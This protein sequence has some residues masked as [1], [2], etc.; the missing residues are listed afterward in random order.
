M[1]ASGGVEEDQ[2][3]A[4]LFCVLDGGL[5]DIDRVRGAHLEDGDIEL[6]AHGLQLLDSGGTV[7]ITGGEQRALAL[8]AH[9][10]GELCT[11]G[12][13]ARALQADQHH[14]ARRLGADVELAV[15]A[16]HEGAQLVVDDLDDHL[17][18]VQGL[19]HVRAD[20]LGGDGLGKVAHDLI[21]HVRL[22][23]S[24]AHLA[25]CLLDVVLGQ[26][27]LAAQLLERLIQFIG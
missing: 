16:A 12:G 27:A 23:Q 15:F 9:I 8:L 17:R 11:V 22:K 10:G 5:G 7:D 25:H 13:L 20:G 14:D 2:V 6:R 21:A 19:Q 1:Q 18:R 3:I 4:V 24:H 26:P